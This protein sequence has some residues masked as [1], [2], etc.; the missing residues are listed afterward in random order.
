MNMFVEAWSATYNADKYP[1]DYYF[2]YLNE[3]Q[4]AKT[5]EQ[6]GESIIALLYWKDGKVIKDSKGAVEVG[7]KRYFLLPTKPN[8]YDEYKHKRTLTSFPFYQWAKEVMAQDSFDA[9]RI[10]DIV[11]R[12]GLYGNNSVVIPAFILHTL[13][14]CIYPLYDQHVERAKRVLLAEDVH[15]NTRDITISSYQEYQQFFARILEECHPLHSNAE[16]KRLDNALWSFGKWM[17]LTNDKE[18]GKQRRLVSSTSRPGLTEEVREYVR[19]ILHKAKE[20]GKEHTD[21]RSGDIHKQMKL[22]D[23][24]PPVCNA[25]ISLGV[26]RHEI[27]HDTPSGKSSTK[28]VRYYLRD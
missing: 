26:F 12:F 25:M 2:Y 10:G 5:S 15:F 4:K 20:E 3:I 28:V 1:I 14:P 9:N 11:N 17:K 24:M 19:S 18:L 7:E 16:M 6:L 8:T 13:S 22:Q 23:R 27:I 21:L